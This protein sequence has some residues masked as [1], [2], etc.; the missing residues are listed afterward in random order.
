MCSLWTI[1]QKK[2]VCDY[3][4]HIISRKNSF[5]LIWKILK[6][7]EDTTKLWDPFWWMVLEKLPQCIP[8]LDAASHETAVDVL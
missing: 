8:V 7:T 6:E 2:N 3:S 1:I 5:R 4:Q